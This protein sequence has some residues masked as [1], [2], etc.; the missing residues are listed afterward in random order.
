MLLH[1]HNGILSLW[2]YKP[3]CIP[4]HKL[5]I[6]NWQ[7]LFSCWRNQK[8][9]SE[10]SNLNWNVSIWDYRVRRAHINVHQAKKKTWVGNFGFLSVWDAHILQKRIFVERILYLSYNL[11]SSKL[12]VC[13][14]Y[15]QQGKHWPLQKEHGWRWRRKCHKTDIDWFLYTKLKS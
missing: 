10:T 12:N 4:D 5:V 15:K 1:K 6:Q 7:W 9:T 11:N 2:I 13:L 8:P 3:L 14:K